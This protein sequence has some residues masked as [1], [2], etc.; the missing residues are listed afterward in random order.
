[1]IKDRLKKKPYKFNRGDKIW[2]PY[3]NISPSAL[4][5]FQASREPE[6]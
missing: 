1:M 4:V 5:E 6:C 3:I 2:R